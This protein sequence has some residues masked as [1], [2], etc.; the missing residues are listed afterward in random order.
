MYLAREGSALSALRFLRV[1]PQNAPDF[2]IAVRFL[3]MI[4]YSHPFST[5]I[6]TTN[7]KLLLRFSTSKKYFEKVI[8]PFQI[9]DSKKGLIKFEVALQENEITDTLKWILRSLD[10]T[11]EAAGQQHNNNTPATYVLEVR[12]AV[13]QLLLVN[14][15]GRELLHL[16]LWFPNP[17]TERD[18]S[19]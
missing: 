5:D 8:G 6:D 7:L 17:S 11:R 13:A 9:S 19:S 10:W 18:G 12:R 14:R 16:S 4:N 15:A 3:C 1:L 2:R